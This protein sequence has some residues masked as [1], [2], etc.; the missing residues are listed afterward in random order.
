MLSRYWL[1]VLFCFLNISMSCSDSIIPFKKAGKTGCW[2][3]TGKAYSIKYS[4]NPRATF[5]KACQLKDFSEM[6]D[7]TVGMSGPGVTPW[8]VGGGEGK[9]VESRRTVVEEEEKKRMSGIGAALWA[10]AILRWCWNNRSFFENGDSS[11]YWHST[12][13]LNPLPPCS[14]L[15]STLN[16]NVPCGM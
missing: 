14:S 12:P 11:R 4:C 2:T 1:Q 5:L 13:M 9:V 8:W 15:H 10:Q 6:Q 3:S 7:P 16:A